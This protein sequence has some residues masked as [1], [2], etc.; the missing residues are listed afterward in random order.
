[1][2]LYDQFGLEKTFMI[3]PF[4]MAVLKVC[5]IVPTFVD[6]TLFLQIIIET[7]EFISRIATKYHKTPF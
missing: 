1:M 3:T 6:S 2:V 7:Y 5:R 4:S